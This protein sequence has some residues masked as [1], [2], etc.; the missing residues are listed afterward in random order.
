MFNGKILYKWW[1]SIAILNYQRVQWILESSTAILATLFIC[2]IS[3]FWWQWLVPLFIATS[4]IWAGSDH[5]GQLDPDLVDLN[6][7]ESLATVERPLDLKGNQDNQVLH[8]CTGSMISTSWRQCCRLG[9]LV[10]HPILGGS[11]LLICSDFDWN[12]VPS[13]AATGKY[14]S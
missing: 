12:D 8:G 2:V 3:I 13:L 5:R 9:C 7:G 11:I 1:F 6:S 4:W 10:L 14:K